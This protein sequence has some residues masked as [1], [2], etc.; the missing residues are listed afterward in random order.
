MSNNLT[1]SLMTPI[2]S[3]PQIILRDDLATVL[4]DYVHQIGAVGGYL[5]ADIKITVSLDEGLRWLRDYIGHHIEVQ[6]HAG[7]IIFEAFIDELELEVGSTSVNVGP[8]MDIVNRAKLKYQ[9]ISYNTNPPIGGDPVD[10]G[11]VENTASTAVYGDMSAL[12]SGGEMLTTEATQAVNRYV[13]EFGYPKR[14]IP[15]ITLSD[16]EAGT[17]FV[18]NISCLGYVH[19][20]EKQLPSDTTTGEFSITEKLAAVIDDNSLFAYTADSLEQ[21]D[22]Q[23]GKAMNGEQ[24]AWDIVKSM[25]ERSDDT[26]QR[27]VFQVLNG[28]VCHYFAVPAQVDY[29]YSLTDPEQA[30]RTAQEVILYRWNI[31]AAKWIMVTDLLG[32]DIPAD[33]LANDPRMMFIESATYQAPWHIA[34]AGGRVSLVEQ[35]FSRFGLGGI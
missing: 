23:V 25:L 13:A 27:Y 7:N 8:F 29:L 3:S 31:E 32:G 9:T 1:I 33:D 4:G 24:T 12:L 18:L 21:N 28:R 6:D 30:I 17:D 2:W 11:F 35:M 14:S 10:T 15:Q 20:F 26:Y 16:Q 19:L 34:I 22:T 5:S